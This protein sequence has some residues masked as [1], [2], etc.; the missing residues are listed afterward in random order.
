MSLIANYAFD[1]SDYSSGI[2]TTI[3]D[4]T[5]NSSDPLDK[6]Y[7][8][9]QKIEDYNQANSGWSPGSDY[10]WKTNSTEPNPFNDNNLY[11]FRFQR[12]SSSDSSKL[13]TRGVHFETTINV[14]PDPYTGSFSIAFWCLF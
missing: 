10:G 9:T 8:L 6:D 11:S 3:T 2:G 14:D 1:S 7:S 5:Y 12:S 13:Y 4:Q